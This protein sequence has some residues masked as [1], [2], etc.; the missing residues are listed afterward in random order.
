VP[1]IGLTGWFYRL[2]VFPVLDNGAVDVKFWDRRTLYESEPPHGF[3]LSAQYREGYY[4][5]HRRWR[6]WSV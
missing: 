6:I 2:H 1:V 4:L 5:A 3:K